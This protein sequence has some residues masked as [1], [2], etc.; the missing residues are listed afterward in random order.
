MTEAMRRA[1]KTAA[2]RERGTYCPIKGV[3]AA[4][5]T[6]L[7][8]ALDRRGFIEWD[9]PIPHVNDSARAAIR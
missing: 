7:L 1:I 6:M 4:A 2:E 3:H 5:E 9:G 8:E